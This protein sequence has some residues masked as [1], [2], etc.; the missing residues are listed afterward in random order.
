MPD[1]RAALEKLVEG[2]IPT[3]LRN[4]ITKT[5]WLLVNRRPTFPGATESVTV[6]P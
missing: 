2:R 6:V 5:A 4:R 3:D 1:V